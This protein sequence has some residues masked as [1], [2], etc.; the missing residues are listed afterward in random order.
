MLYK[1]DIPEV[2]DGKLNIVAD[3]ATLLDRDYLTRF[4]M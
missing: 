3:G 2:P 1:N 4:A